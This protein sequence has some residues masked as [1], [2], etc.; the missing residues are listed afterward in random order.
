[1]YEYQITFLVNNADRSVQLASALP[2]IVKKF[3][4]TIHLINITQDRSGNLSKA[5]GVFKAG[6]VEGDLCQITAIGV[7]AELACFVI[8]DLVADLYT[9]IGTD[10]YSVLSQHVKTPLPFK[11][12][13]FDYAK[14]QTILTKFE[15]LK[16]IAQLIYPKNPDELLL[17]FIKR[18]ETSSTCVTPGIA[19]PHVMFKESH[20]LSIAAI[21]TED[22]ID[23]QSPIGKTHLAIGLVMPDKPTKAQIIA[24]TNLTRNLLNHTLCER[25]LLTRNSSELQSIIMYATSRLI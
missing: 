7:D 17:A 25:L 8:K 13:H 11:D 12:I 5:L 19:L 4:S 21:S 9:V 24:V 18:E 22:A 20:Q 15:C 16:G 6:M 3:K 10:I 14:A 2:P 23:W 1:M